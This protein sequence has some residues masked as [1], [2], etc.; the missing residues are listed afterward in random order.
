MKSKSNYLKWTKMSMVF[1]WID[2]QWSMHK[3]DKISR[4]TSRNIA[5]SVP[6]SV[7][8]L[9]MLTDA[10]TIEPSAI[11]QY[12]TFRVTF[13]SSS[14]LELIEFRVMRHFLNILLSQIFEFFRKF[15]CWN[16]RQRR[17]KIVCEIDYLWNRPT[18]IER[19]KDWLINRLKSKIM[20]FNCGMMFKNPYNSLSLHQV[21]ISLFYEFIKHAI[22]QLLEPNS[23]GYQFQYITFNA[24]LSFDRTSSQYRYFF[25]LFIFNSKLLYSRLLSRSIVEM[26]RYYSHCLSMGN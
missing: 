21:C 5:I 12:V 13:S 23:N 10:L 25:I 8:A 7:C 20:L 15:Q 9:C 16:D 4:K 2:L 19:Q 6:F 17:L 1:I 11:G 24:T 26:D 3:C 18:Y 22:K 14:S